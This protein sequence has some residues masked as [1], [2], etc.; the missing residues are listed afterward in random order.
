MSVCCPPTAFDLVTSSERS[1]SS[2]AYE[3]QVNA[4]TNQYI[5]DYSLIIFY[6]LPNLY[7]KQ[8]LHAVPFMSIQTLQSGLNYQKFNLTVRIYYRNRTLVI[9]P[10]SKAELLQTIFASMFTIDNGH[11]P[12]VSTPPILL[13]LA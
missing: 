2:L 9:D 12:V 10:T 8:R 1:G 4:A 13:T 6:I 3:V 5:N 11:I 7:I